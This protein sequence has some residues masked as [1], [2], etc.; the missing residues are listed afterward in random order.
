MKIPAKLDGKLEFV[1]LKDILCF[2]IFQKKIMFYTDDHVYHSISSIN[3]YYELTR[4]HGFEMLDRN[5]VVQVDKITSYDPY[6][7]IVFFGE[8][9]SRYCTVSGKSLEF[10]KNLK[11]K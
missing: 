4:E 6:Q 7:K 1:S 9:G 5:N 11:I 8:N 2:T 3:D 10:L